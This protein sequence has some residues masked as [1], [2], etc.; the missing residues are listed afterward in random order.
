MNGLPMAVSV[1]VAAVAHCVLTVEIK[2]RVF[3]EVTAVFV[4]TRR[5]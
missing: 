4:L 3:A 1:L 2:G 5:L